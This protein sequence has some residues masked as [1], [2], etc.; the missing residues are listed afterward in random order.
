MSIPFLITGLPR[1]RTAWLSAFFDCEHEGMAGHDCVDSMLGDLEGNGNCDS[2]LCLFTDGVLSAAAEGRCNLVVIQRPEAEVRASLRAVWK[3]DFNV[4]SDDILDEL[5]PGYN[6]I[7]DSP[8]ALLVPYSRL[9]DEGAMRT[10]WSFV[11]FGTLFPAARNYR[12]QAMKITQIF[13]VAISRVK[14]A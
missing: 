3:D 6:Q 8:H 4:T 9:S 1:S 5:L 2:S 11:R 13:D 7:K 14:A 12:M 10:I